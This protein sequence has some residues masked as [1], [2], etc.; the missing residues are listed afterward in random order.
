M[1]PEVP[2]LGPYFGRLGNQG[3]RIELQKP[4]VDSTNRVHYVAADPIDYETEPP[5][6][7]RW[8]NGGGSSLQRIDA[9][10]YSNDPLNWGEG[11]PTPG[12][13]NGVVP[14]PVVLDQPTRHILGPG[15]TLVLTINALRG[16]EPLTLQWFLNGVL[17]PDATGRSFSLTNASAS[18][19]G[20]YDLVIWNADGRVTNRIATVTVL[21]PPRVIRSPQDQVASVGRN[22]TLSVE[23]AGA[24]LL[25]YQWQ[26]GAVNLP[27]ATNALLRLDRVSGNQAGAYRVI[28]SNRY[29]AATSEVAWLSLTRDRSAPKLSVSVPAMNW[30]TTNEHLIAQGAALDDSRVVALEYSHNGAAF[31]QLTNPA[32]FAQWNIP[33]ELT[34]GTNTLEVRA[35]DDSGNVTTVYRRFLHSALARLVLAVQGAGTIEGAPV[36]GL[37]EIGRRYT[38]T[39]VPQL[40][41]TFAYWSGDFVSASPRLS[42][43][44]Q[45]D[46]IVHAIF[47]PNLFYTARGTYYGLLEPLMTFPGSPSAERGLCRLTLNERGV[48]S[49][50]WRLAG[51]RFATSGQLDSKGNVADFVAIGPTNRMVYLNA[52]LK[53]GQT[54]RGSIVMNA[55][56]Y[57]LL[58]AYRAPTFTATNPSPYRGRYTW[59]AF[60]D[61]PTVGA[62]FGTIVIDE[63]QG[64]TFSARLN[65]GTRFVQ[66]SLF[67]AGGWFPI[68]EEPTRGGIFSGWLQLRP[69]QPDEPFMVSSN[70]FWSRLPRPGGSRHPDGFEI[71]V[72]IIGD[73]YQAP[74]SSQEPIL[75]FTRGNFTASNSD[76]S[77]GLNVLLMPGDRMVSDPP[78]DLSG[79]FDPKQGLIS[80][81]FRFPDGRTRQFQGA[82]NQR[83]QQGQG[84]FLDSFFGGGFELIGSE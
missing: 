80:G 58:N 42:F 35:L 41:S 18:D 12:L 22:M 11:A 32:S 82:V 30:R 3:E 59:T 7:A 76:E 45:P 16:N 83:T 66:K 56:P 55:G 20:D 81:T 65:D 46:L 70:H 25:R 69:G 43:V 51:I 23:A 48:Y 64:A 74:A 8:V 17:I 60:S 73:R 13:P 68:Y 5:W 49:A 47:V 77:V 57:V 50:T 14:Y 52:D 10:A 38:L 19:T 54:V 53:D 27:G 78:G 2:L 36:S 67:S 62:S 9:R 21:T 63:N 1:P 33:L 26:L 84:Y 61:S 79:R 31:V 75:N 44:M 24:P 29:G 72:E 39:A 28:V 15:G 37:F 40:D 6:P 4:A 71:A 34:A